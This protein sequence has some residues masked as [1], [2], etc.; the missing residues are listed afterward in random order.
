MQIQKKVI[1]PYP[2]E[3]LLSVY[4]MRQEIHEAKKRIMIRLMFLLGLFQNLNRSEKASGS[5]SLDLEYV[6]MWPICISG[7]CRNR[8]PYVQEISVLDGSGS[9]ILLL[10]GAFIGEF[11]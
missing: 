8:N 1:L 4:V 2:H 10:A 11:G 3:Q 5:P 9:T 6:A 7:S